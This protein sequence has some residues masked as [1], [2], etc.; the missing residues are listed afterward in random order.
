[1]EKI[2]LFQITATSKDGNK[3]KVFKCAVK[4]GDE[5]K[6]VNINLS[7]EV[8]DKLNRDM[9]KADLKY[10]VNLEVLDE[11]YFIV[12]EEGTNGTWKKIVVT[13]YQRIEQGEYSHSNENK[14]RIADLFK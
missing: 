14:L 4:N 5:E 6:V 2:K 12:E 9:I 3:F 10:P 7:N 13:D 11:D 1:M 8:K